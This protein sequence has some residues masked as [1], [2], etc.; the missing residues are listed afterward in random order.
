LLEDLTISRDDSPWTHLIADILPALEVA[1]A[2]AEL[3]QGRAEGRSVSLLPDRAT[4][5]YDA[6][7]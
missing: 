7:W 6:A 1:V 4:A 3:C 5:L 2:T